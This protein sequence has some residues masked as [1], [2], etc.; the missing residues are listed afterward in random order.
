M[1]N[2]KKLEVFKEALKKAKEGD[3]FNYDIWLENNDVNPRTLNLKYFQ[4]YF[5]ANPD[6]MIGSDN[7]IQKVAEY[8]GNFLKE[9]KGFYHIP[10]IGIK[11][12]GK[13]LILHLLERFTND[14]ETN[15]GNRIDLTEEKQYYLQDLDTKQV[16][17]ARNRVR[18]HFIDN[19][20]K[21]EN[22]VKILE[23][24]R[25]IKKDSV[26]VTSW[27][28]ES[29]IRY[30]KEIDNILPISEEFAITPL[31]LNGPKATTGDIA[32][33]F[34]L[35]MDNL[36][37]SIMHPE[38]L[39][40]KSFPYVYPNFLDAKFVH[41]E[42]SELF[43]KYTKG[44]PLVS[45]KMLLKCIEKVFKLRK[46]N[47]DESIIVDVAIEM[48]LFYTNGR[49]KDLT[50]LHLQILSS[51]LFATTNKGMRPMQLAKEFDLDKSTISYHLKNLKDREII[52]DQ[53]LGKSKY[54]K[55]KEIYIPFI[56]LKI[57]YQFYL[58]A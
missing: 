52:E 37:H 22:I 47:I 56:Q 53:K 5:K 49:L 42:L 58:Y 27:T 51:I 21:V 57:L 46:K 1:K 35:F 43:H 33:E 39:E 17:R 19:C 2:S 41:E 36:L 38:K 40:D 25:K 14:F 7:I 6:K 48:G 31:K 28:P 32:N 20:E 4:S 50:Q 15:L 16:I 54:Y 8:I 30:Q 9:K 34:F 24:I 29:W 23:N 44:I 26:Y 10:I 12:S 11:G 18:I 45:I 55:V 13:T 3:L